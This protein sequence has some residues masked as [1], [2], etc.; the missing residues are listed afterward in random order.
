MRVAKM[1]P[2]S[3]GETTNDLTLKLLVLY[4][5]DLFLVLLLHMLKMR[6]KTKSCHIWAGLLKHWN[7]L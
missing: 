4:R 3:F 7:L 5:Y 2:L 6:W 1:R